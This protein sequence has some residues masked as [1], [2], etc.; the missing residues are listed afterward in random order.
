MTNMLEV[1]GRIVSAHVSMCAMTSEEV[2][3]EINSVHATL[4]NL[5]QDASVK[6]TRHEG[7]PAV[8]RKQAFKKTEVVCMLCG[9]GGM[10]TL[11]RHLKYAHSMNP[12]EYRTKFGIP[13]EQPLTARDFSAHRRTLATA[14][15]LA[16]YLVKA[17][18]VRA[19]RLKGK[20]DNRAALS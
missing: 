2:L 6:T 1:V 17:R 4:S 7:M 14:H 18:A 19:E 8:S 12:G 16:D 13:R 11:A 3:A 15:G 10:R 5:H 9:K 20:K